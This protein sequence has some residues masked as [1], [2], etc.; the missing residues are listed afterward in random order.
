VQN[1]LPGRKVKEILS[2]WPNIS[3]CCDDVC[4]R[5]GCEWLKHN[6]CIVSP[7]KKDNTFRLISLI[8]DAT[9]LCFGK[10][11][12]DINSFHKHENA[13][14]RCGLIR[15]NYVVT[16]VIFLTNGKKYFNVV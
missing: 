2:D 11:L 12:S 6:T 14:A 3:V 8:L 10:N 5:P 13:Y 4:V 15:L 1:I 9:L 7:Y 16:Q